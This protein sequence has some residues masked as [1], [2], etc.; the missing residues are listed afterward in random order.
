MTD[1]DRLARW[2][3]LCDEVT[4]RMKEFTR[5]YV[6][7]LAGR[8]GR[9]TDIGTGT[10]VANGGRRLLTC[11][12]VARFE[13]TAH[14]I[15]GNGHI[16]IEP[17]IWCIEP[18]VRIDAASSAIPEDE[19]RRISGS[20]KMLALS[21]FA[22]RHAPADKEVLF[23]RGIAGE[24]AH[25][26]AFGTDVTLTGYCSQEK[27]ASG[28]ADIFEMLW[29]P[30]EAQLTAD[31]DPETRARFKYDNPAGFS[32]SLVWNTRFVEEGCDL[33][34]WSPKD[35]RVTGLLRRYDPDTGT[36][37]V[38]RVEHLFAWLRQ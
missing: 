10:F 20:A 3:D 35:A 33:S 22:D 13:P 1:R 36:L 19:C 4:T 37:L 30:R 12:H 9:P 25:V 6:A 8:P 28:D 16:P 21:N 15:D 14:Y 11:E 5:P 17:G 32:G 26:S 24:N 31:T 7:V 2:T 38:W 18:D 34:R 23:F 29:S 27:K